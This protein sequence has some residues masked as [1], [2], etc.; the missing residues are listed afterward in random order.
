MGPSMN[1]ILRG[2][3]AGAV[4]TV[5]MSLVM[6]QQRE[7]IPPEVVTANL[8]H[9]T[10]VDL[11][12]EAHRTATTVSHFGFGAL[13]GALYALT[14]DRKWRLRPGLKGPLFGLGVW[15]VSYM[16]WLPAL[17]LMPHAARQS[18]ERNSNMV[19][20]HLVWGFA[21]SSLVRKQP[22]EIFSEAAQG[23]SGKSFM[24]RFVRQSFA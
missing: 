7:R 23:I 19:L 3:L 4:A 18:K 22:G 9:K 8:E 11:S 24:G 16:G 1:A 21:L 20:S 17:G 13:A 2:A 14:L 12:S 5:P 15:A 6:V 10:G